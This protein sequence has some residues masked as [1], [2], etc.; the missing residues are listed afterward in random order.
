MFAENQVE[1]PAAAHMRTGAAEMFEDRGF[2]T[3]RFFQGIC[4]QRQRRK[5]P[6]VVDFGCRF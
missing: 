5:I 1:R 2:S 3:A 6:I 4:K